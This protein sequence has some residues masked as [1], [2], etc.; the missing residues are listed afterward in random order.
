MKNLNWQAELE[1]HLIASFNAS[2]FAKLNQDTQCR[3]IARIISGVDFLRK[4][5]LLI[6]PSTMAS[7]FD[8][9]N[10][11]HCLLAKS[12]G[13]DF[14]TARSTLNLAANEAVSL[15]Y[16]HNGISSFTSDDGTTHWSWQEIYNFLWRTTGKFF[17]E[18]PEF[19]VI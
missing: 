2:R 16:I 1:T 10:A 19:G 3:A 13:G 5:R 14:Y 4:H 7:D 8:I 15:G 17:N 9:S 6:I 12:T 18:H 11:Y